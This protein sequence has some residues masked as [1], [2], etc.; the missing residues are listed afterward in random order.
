MLRVVRGE[1][2][3]HLLPTVNLTHHP[4]STG[5]DDVIQFRDE[6]EEVGIERDSVA[7][8]AMKRL[9]IICGLERVAVDAE[10]FRA[11]FPHPKVY[12]VRFVENEHLS[13]G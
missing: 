10:T 5:E 7:D 9:H 6:S 3:L 13:P 8:P 2:V 12:D 1:L 4:F 11:D